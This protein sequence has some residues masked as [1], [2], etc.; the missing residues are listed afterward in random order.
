VKRAAILALVTAALAV[1][2]ELGTAD[3]KA[4]EVSQN[5]TGYVARGAKFVSVSA[6]WVQPS[7]DCLVRATRTES[8]FWVGLGGDAKSSRR[9]EQVGTTADCTANGEEY[10][11]WY[12]IWPAEAVWLAFDVEP[13]DR[14]SAAVRVQGHTVTFE[15]HNLSTGKRFS[16]TVRMRAPD[17]SSA[18]W[19]AEAPTAV[20][21]HGERL[22]PLTNF[23]TVTFT[24]AQATSA[25]G[26]TGAISDPAWTS[27]PIAFWSESAA[28]R[29]QIDQFVAQTTEA[30][31]LPS[32]LSH[33]GK[34]FSATWQRGAPTAGRR[35]APGAI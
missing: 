21:E 25:S 26:H 28:G 23:G 20:L 32:R 12:E 35:A 1:C 10:W 33:H 2:V 22:V 24:H 8:S 19:I 11:A 30:H 5:W 15:L 17:T 27:R 3:A 9:L 16:K 13:G 4:I 7:A 18:E 34:A 29:G 14:V 31:V 6:T